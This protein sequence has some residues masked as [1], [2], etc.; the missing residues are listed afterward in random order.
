VDFEPWVKK[1]VERVLAT[2]VEIT[3]SGYEQNKIMYS[4]NYIMSI[5]L[6]CEVMAKIAKIYP[7]KKEY[8]TLKIKDMLSLGEKILEDL[9]DDVFQKYLL[10]RDFRDRTVLRIITDN[11][12]YLLLSC[13]KVN[14]LI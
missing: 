2:M 5:C 3:G 1:E 12:F 10:D 8:V 4:Y 9:N 7:Q 13:E 11:K 6:A 14:R